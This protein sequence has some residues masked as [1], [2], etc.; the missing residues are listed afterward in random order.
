MPEHDI[1]ALGAQYREARD[2]IGAHR[3]RQAQ[4]EQARGAWVKAHR[5]VP[6][7][8]LYDRSTGVPIDPELLALSAAVDRATADVQWCRAVTVAAAEALKGMTLED[9]IAQN[10]AGRAAHQR[11]VAK[12]LSSLDG[13][14]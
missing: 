4:A 5:G 10:D 2:S 1:E 3:A 9:A 12:A 7:D 11:S 6:A 8:K 13:D 14:D